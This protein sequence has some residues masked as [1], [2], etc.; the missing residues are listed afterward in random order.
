MK[1]Y[2]EPVICRIYGS[3]KNHVNVVLPILEWTDKNVSDFVKMQN[4][5][6]HPLYY[7]NGRFDVRRRLGCEGCPLQSD[8][9]LSD[10]KR[11]PALVKA[12][13][14]AGQEWWY[15]PRVKPPRSH[16]KFESIYDLFAHNIFFDS[17]ESFS[18]AKSGLFGSIDCKQALEKYFNIE[19]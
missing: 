1:T 7:V 5:Q 8:N 10:F 4:I 19:L 11:K 18:I 14:R 16:E 15:K 17:Y 12:W 2:K 13:I 3:K 6:C 9:G